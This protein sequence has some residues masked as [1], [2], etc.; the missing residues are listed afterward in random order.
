M[1]DRAAARQGLT[2]DLAIGQGGRTR[3][4]E[5]VQA[6][7]LE[8]PDVDGITLLGNT[9]VSVGEEAIDVTGY[10]AVRGEFVVTVLEGARPVADDEVEVLLFAPASTLNTGNVRDARTVDAP[11]RL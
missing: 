8:D 10:E 4:S 1:A 3:V 11:G 2:F 5:E 9:S 7:I 6:A